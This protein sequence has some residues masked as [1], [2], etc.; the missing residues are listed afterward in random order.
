[1]SHK[2]NQHLGRISFCSVDCA[3]FDRNMLGSAE[4]DETDAAA[5]GGIDG[6]HGGAWRRAGVRA[7]ARTSRQL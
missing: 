3:Y 4:A 5:G 7:D 6:G 1:M 2:K